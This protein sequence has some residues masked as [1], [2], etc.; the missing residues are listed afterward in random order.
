MTCDMFTA[1]I[2]S[3]K[4]VESRWLYVA[5]PRL[6]LEQSRADVPQ[7]VASN[8]LASQGCFDTDAFMPIYVP[9]LLVVA[10]MR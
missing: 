10:M 1:N 7:L 4:H 6:N 9:S 3:M 2:A 8:A 5:I